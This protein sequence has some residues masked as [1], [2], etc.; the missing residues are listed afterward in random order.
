[1]LIFGENSNLILYV[2]Q[3]QRKNNEKIATY[4]YDII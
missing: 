2:I 4:V 3:F 1:M